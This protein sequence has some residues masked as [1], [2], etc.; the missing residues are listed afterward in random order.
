MWC[1]DDL[2]GILD[3][4]AMV[5]AHTARPPGCCCCP[6]KTIPSAPRAP[7]LAASLCACWCAGL[8]DQWVG[9]ADGRPEQPRQEAS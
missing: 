6:V 8:L 1:F 2:H 3:V 4:C 9:G 5:M 7:L